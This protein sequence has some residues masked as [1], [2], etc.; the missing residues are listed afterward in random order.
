[1]KRT[2]YIVKHENTL[3]SKKISYEAH[4]RGVLTELGV[5]NCLNYVS[6]SYSCTSADDCE[7]KLRIELSPT[8]LTVIRVT[9]I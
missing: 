2:Y 9:K 1:M 6:P 5:Y 7:R 4:R 3:E 8:K